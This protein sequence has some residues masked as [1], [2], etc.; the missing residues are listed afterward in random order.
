[1]GRA[2][3]RLGITQPSL[4]QQIHRLERETGLVLFRRHPKGVELTE[5]GIVLAREARPALEAL[6][7]AVRMAQRADVPEQLR[8]VVPNAAF[9]AHPAVAG[10]VATAAAALGGAEVRYASALTAE[11]ASLL[12][13]GQAD[14]AVVFAPLDD[15]DMDAVPVFTDTPAVALPVDH[16][17]AEHDELAIAAL[18]P[19]PI[20]WWERATIPASHDTLVAACRRAGFEPRL[21][22]IPDVPGLLA[23]MLADGAGV[24]VISEFVA[25][26]LDDP[27]IVWRPLIRPHMVLNGLLAWPH[28]APTRA[29]RAVA[30]AASGARER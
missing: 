19:Y 2:A 24:S 6:A 28:A 20:L 15:A 26:S 30:A 16:L 23:A 17:L 12:R 29:A 11:A 13:S 22:E 10:V 27:R 5:P 21:I 18:A 25:R 1:M 8:V 4:S 14:V 3:A 9:A 7:A